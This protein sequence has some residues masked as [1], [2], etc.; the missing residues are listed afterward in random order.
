MTPGPHDAADKTLRVLIVGADQSLEDEFRHALSGVPDT[1]GVLYFVDTY[2]HA[3]EVARSRQPAFIVIEID[4]EVSEVAAL[5]RDLHELMP[6]A[7]IAGAF[8]QD[9]IERGRS[10]SATI[11]DLLR[12]HVSDFLRRPF[13]ATEL[14]SVLDRLFSKAAAAPVEQGRVVSFLSNKGGVGKS[15]L[16]VNVACG[17]ALRHPEQVLLIDTSLQAGTCAMMLDLKPT[18]S[19]IDAIRERDRLDSTLLR[20]L[21]LKHGTGL[22]VLAAPADALEGS[23]VDDET[24]VRILHLAR[25]SFKY[26]IV[27]TF[28][29]LDNV[30]MT[31][32]DLTDLA[33]VVAQGTAPAVA[34]IA[35]LLP[36]LEGLGVP[37]S[38]QRLVLSYNYQ[39]FLGNLRPADI[40][41][42]L[43]RTLDYVVPY[44]KRVLT[45]MNTGSPHILH[46]SWW[47]GFRRAINHVVEDLDGGAVAGLTD[48]RSPQ[49]SDARRATGMGHP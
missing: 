16:S 48:A 10:E 30:M 14:R 9:K 20:H 43:Q 36:V 18:T 22:R 35:R 33:F 38:R 29:I 28:P 40:A 17:L 31:I 2:R 5:S 49:V 47:Q 41:D 23:E 34:S 26:V 24:I 46:A 15:T 11:I 27:D 1:H 37:P 12:A 25:R 8:R 19:I 13:S 44:E 4:R 39:P 7:A 45:S 6:G 21:T 42:R 32:L 3:L